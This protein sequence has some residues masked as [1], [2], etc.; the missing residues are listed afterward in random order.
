MFNTPDEALEYIKPFIPHDL[1]LAKNALSKELDSTPEWVVEGIL[2]LLV[3]TLM[4]E[5]IK[6]DLLARLEE[7]WLP[8]TIPYVLPDT[9]GTS[10]N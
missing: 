8:N 1:S 4:L 9:S 5:D 6:T 10:S 2:F 3:N 7:H